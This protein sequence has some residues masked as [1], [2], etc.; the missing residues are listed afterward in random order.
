MSQSNMNADPIA[1]ELTA[2]VDEYNNALNQGRGPFDLAR[3]AHL[4]KRDDQ[5]T[6][7]DLSPPN[8]G[9]VG[10][11][12]YERAWYE[13]MSNYASFHIKANDDLRIGHRGDM[14]WTAF[15]FKVWGERQGG[16]AY[17]AEGRATLVWLREGARWLITHEHVSTPRQPPTP[18][19]AV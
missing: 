17:D 18:S 9:Y 5:F 15:S 4:Y 1:L 10:W 2:L 7:Y 11:K 13:I 8:A 3:A 12:E 16:A 6:A 14:A 19:R